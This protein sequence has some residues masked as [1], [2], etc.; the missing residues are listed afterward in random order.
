MLSFRTSTGTAGGSASARKLAEQSHMQP[1]ISLH[2]LLLAAGVQHP[3]TGAFCVFADSPGSIGVHLN[4]YGLKD[5]RP[6]KSQ[7]SWS[8]SGNVNGVPNMTAII[9][10]AFTK[11]SAVAPNLGFTQLTSG[12]DIVIG[13]Q[14]LGAPNPTGGVVLGS[15]A[16]N[17]STINFNSNPLVAFA[18]QLPGNPSLLAVATHEIGHALGLLHATTPTSVMYPF[19]PGT[20]TLSPDDLAGIRALYGWAPKN[21]V[22]GIGSEAGPA[23]CACGGTLVM[24]M[25]GIDDDHNVYFFTSSDGQNWSSQKRTVPG[26]GSSDSPSLAWDGTQLWMVCK[27]VPGDQG[28]YWANWDLVNTWTVRQPIAGAGSSHG[29]SIAIVGGTPILVCKGVEGDSGVYFS[30]FLAGSWSAPIKIGGMGTSDRPAV[31]ADPVT[32]VPRIVCKGVQGDHALYTSMLRGLFWEPREEVAWVVAGNGGAGTAEVG[33][34]GSEFGPSLVT[35]RGKIFMVWRGIDDDQE[36]WFT[37]AAPDPAIA[38]QSIAEWSTQANVQGFGTSS[39]PAIAAF[40]GNIYLACKGI[41]GDR[42]I[43]TTFV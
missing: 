22:L 12:G 31:A 15:T 33:R 13:V 8:V 38:G 18:P 5:G 1:P 24:A 6:R 19:N 20:E 16:S 41:A 34:P 9:Q 30:T 23:L 36:L 14:N 43:Y 35:A 3:P 40:G 7:L 37:Q 42:G 4:A 2:A 21:Q 11:W 27:G 28:L 32:G 25:R 29:P 17:G 10:A 39:R 26:V